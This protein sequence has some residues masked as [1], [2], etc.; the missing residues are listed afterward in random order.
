MMRHFTLACCVLVALS[1]LWAVSIS[2]NAPGGDGD[3]F[4]G[5]LIL[6]Y[7]KGRSADHAFTLENVEFAELNGSK[8]LQGTHADTGED[9][10]WM[11][12][13]K[14]IVAWDAVES[15]TVYDSV[16]DY[17]QAIAQLDDDIL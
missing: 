6:L 7:F 11:K 8:M 1:A 16:E 9:L 4:E 5:K 15:L 12:G 17:R 3:S 10:D 13:R 2:A 14:A